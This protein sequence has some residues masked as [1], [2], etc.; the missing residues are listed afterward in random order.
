MQPPNDLLPDLGGLADTAKIQIVERDL[1]WRFLGSLVVAGDA[2]PIQDFAGGRRF[3]RGRRGRRSRALR[4]GGL[5]TARGNRDD[6]QSGC[7]EKRGYSR[8]VPHSFPGAF[9]KAPKPLKSFLR[10]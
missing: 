10:A 1:A 3:S 9:P 8:P 2:V 6:Q 4:V 7:D 5:W